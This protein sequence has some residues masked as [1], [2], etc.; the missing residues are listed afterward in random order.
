M[1]S[2]GMFSPMSDLES[3]EDPKSGTNSLKQLTKHIP[4]R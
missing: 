3:K 4:E 1:Q 2:V